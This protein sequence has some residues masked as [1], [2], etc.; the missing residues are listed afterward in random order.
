MTLLGQLPHHL[1]PIYPRHA[2]AGGRYNPRLRPP[3]QDD[4]GSHRDE[5]GVRRVA[6]NWIMLETTYFL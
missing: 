3:L 1:V 4:P 2:M 6:A 5:G